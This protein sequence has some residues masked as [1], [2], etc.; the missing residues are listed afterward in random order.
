MTQNQR[1]KLAEAVRL[2]RE[3]LN[4]N[5]SEQLPL[6]SAPDVADLTKLRQSTIEF[7]RALYRTFGMKSINPNDKQ[8]IKLQ[9]ETG[10]MRMDNFYL[11]M[12]TRELIETKLRLT[13]S[14]RGVV[15]SFRFIKTIPQ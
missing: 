12:K 2:L 8:V 10:M 5:G 13:P 14:G 1:N 6:I 15:E 3:I 4:E 7:A 11:S 9:A